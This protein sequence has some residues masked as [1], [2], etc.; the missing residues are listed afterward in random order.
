MRAH[1]DVLAA[2]LPG[3][4]CSLW[5]PLYAARPRGQAAGVEGGASE[6]AITG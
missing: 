4:R 3:T 6:F 5:R 2:C 1:R